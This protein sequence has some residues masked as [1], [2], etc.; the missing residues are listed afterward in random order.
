MKIS[1][2]VAKLVSASQ[3][4]AHRDPEILSAFRSQNNQIQKNPAEA[5]L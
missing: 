1:F 2:H 4:K 3:I 5:G